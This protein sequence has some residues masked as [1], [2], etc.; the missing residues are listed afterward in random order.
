MDE[1]ENSSPAAETIVQTGDEGVA[2]EESMTS[3]PSDTQDGLS[4]TNVSADTGSRQ[5][6]GKDCVFSHNI[7][8]MCK[9]ITNIFRHLFY[10][11][12]FFPF[13]D[14]KTISQTPFL[15]FSLTV[16]GVLLFL[17]EQFSLEIIFKGKR[18]ILGI[19]RNLF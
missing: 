7:F 16:G 18:K 12:F 5:T 2:Q 3:S 9:E 13:K 8:V 4:G 11:Y 10:F 14:E 19:F 6:N 15:F 1:A 17:L